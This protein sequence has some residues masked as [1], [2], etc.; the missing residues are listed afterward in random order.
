VLA[1]FSKELEDAV[2]NDCKTL[3][4]VGCGSSSPIKLFSHKLFCV[5]VDA[6]EP[7]IEKSKNKGIHDEYFTM[8][9]SELHEKFKPQT[10][11]CVLALDVIEHL[12]KDESQRLLDA[13]EKIAKKK[14][15]VFTPNGFVPQEAF[16]NN[17]CQVH[18]SGWTVKE[19]KTRGYRVIGI[20]G[21]RTLLGEKALTK[22]RPEPFWGFISLLTQILVR[23][24]PSFAFQIL[25]VKRIDNM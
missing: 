23:N 3:L 2:G 6:H 25:C 22:F 13:M 18:K 8:K 12:S 16:D 17:P 5:G 11:D 20:N 4:D 7:S 9:F 14:V 24:H 10:F 1:P 21:L 19:M 15:I